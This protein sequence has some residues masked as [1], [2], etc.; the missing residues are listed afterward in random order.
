MTFCP[1]SQYKDLFGAANTGVHSYRVADSPMIDYVMTI[2]GA[3][4]L[5]YITR[6]PL[7]LTTI[8]LFILGLVL[9]LLF[10]VETSSL[11]YLGL[12]CK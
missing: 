4:I 7:V 5:A 8:G 6:I 1:F 9:H 12:T 10:G 3:I 2:I 11:K